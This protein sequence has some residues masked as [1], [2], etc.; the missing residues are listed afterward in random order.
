MNQ[1]HSKKGIT[2]VE[3]IIAIAFTAL[4]ITAACSML[5]LASNFFKSGTESAVNQENTALAESYLQ[6]Y[7]STA[8]IVSD[9]TGTSTNYA[10]FSIAT[11]ILTIDR[12]SEIG[13]IPSTIT[14]K[15]D[16]ISNLDLQLTDNLLSY[17]ITSQDGKYILSGVII[18]NNYTSGG[19][20]N[21]DGTNGKCLFLDF[22]SP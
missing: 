21:I 1:F 5:Y 16:G 6:Q 3:L 9:T 8:F 12:T 2:L 13:G 4:I 10:V 15:I 11:D 19:V 14:T 18:V 7:L 22:V 17:K 20:S